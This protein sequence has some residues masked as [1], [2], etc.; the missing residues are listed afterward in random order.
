MSKSLGELAIEAIEGSANGEKGRR[1]IRDYIFSLLE[2][3]HADPSKFLASDED[4]NTFVHFLMQFLN[5]V[6]PDS[7]WPF[8]LII[9]DKTK[10]SALPSE[11]REKDLKT[12]NAA[13]QVE[14]LKEAGWKQDAALSQVIEETG[15]K[16]SDIFTVR[17]TILFANMLLADA[18][19]KSD[20][21]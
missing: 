5:V 18:R 4:R 9:K 13:I 6:D 11:R 14:R 12:A 10:N 15:V 21:Y 20:E 1:H 17:K 19:E 8:E 2:E 3:Y 7:D 16:R